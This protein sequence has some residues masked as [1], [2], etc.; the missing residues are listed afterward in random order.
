MDLN[1]PLG[2]GPPPRS[3]RGLMLVLAG[4]VA[5]FVLGGLGWVL[6]TADPHGGEPFAVAQLH[7]ARL[8]R[9]GAASALVDPL[10]TGSLAPPAVR[11]NAPL[12]P[13][14]GGRSEPLDEGAVENG[15]RV[16]RGATQSSTQASATPT[17][18][19]LVIDVSRQLDGGL[20]AR[21]AP[22]SMVT[23]KTPA[24]AATPAMPRVAIYI[25]G[26]GP[27]PDG[28]ADRHRHHASRRIARV[29]ALCRQGV[30]L[31]R[32]GSREGPRGVAATTHAECA[33]QR[34]WPPFTHARRGPPTPS[35]VTSTGS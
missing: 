12:P 7:Q 30:R 4:S 9:D 23:D 29:P 18:G 19:P 33:R 14:A 24:A 2:L 21:P 17:P 31:G 16:Y 22:P 26:M 10:P 3:R 6:A 15:V 34:T 20:K 28:D 5:V 32:R 27:Q 13:D 1:A 8:S 35:R 25:S 11:N